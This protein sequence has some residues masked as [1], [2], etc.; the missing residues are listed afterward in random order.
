M[1]FCETCFVFFTSTTKYI[2][3]RE[4]VRTHIDCRDVSAVFLL[5]FYRIEFPISTSFSSYIELYKL[6]TSIKYLT[7]YLFCSYEVNNAWY[8]DISIRETQSSE[9]DLDLQSAGKTFNCNWRSLLVTYV[10]AVQEMVRFKR[11][12]RTF[13]RLWMCRTWVDMIDQ[14]AQGAPDLI[15]PGTHSFVYQ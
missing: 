4:T 10:F 3:F 14:Y 7:N 9:R 2:G 6:Y 11:T 12:Q 15:I 13:V 5:F 1:A 8:T